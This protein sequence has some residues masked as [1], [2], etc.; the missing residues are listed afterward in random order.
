[1]YAISHI[2]AKYYNWS[3]RL[4]VRA[5][6]LWIIA[7]FL[8]L[9]VVL[10]ALPGWLFILANIALLVPLFACLKALSDA[11]DHERQQDR[12]IRKSLRIKEQMSRGQRK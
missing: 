8:L 10:F 3:R 2:V 5:P 11:F 1:M 12:Q 6:V 9:I 4:A 7:M